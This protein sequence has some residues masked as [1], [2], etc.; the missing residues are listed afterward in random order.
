MR[1]DRDSFRVVDGIADGLTVHDEEG[2]FEYVSPS[3]GALSG[4]EASA[5]IG[6][7][8]CDLGLLH[9]DDVDRAVAAH[10]QALLTSKPW[11]FSYRLRR[12]DEVVVRLE[13]TG[14]V[15]NT[16]AGLRIVATHRETAPLAPLV[17]ELAPE[18]QLRL[19]TQELADRQQRF[20]TMV[21]QRARAPLTSVV[22]IAALLRQRG[23][24]LDP[25]PRR[26]LIE[27]LHTDS[28][29]LMELLKDVA[30]ADKLTRAD[31]AVQ[32]R[33]ADVHALV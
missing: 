8:P 16:A 33:V 15:I 6:G 22:G 19:Q 28:L 14:G 25:N 18:R 20:L 9:P 26:A 4:F 13:S 29:L 17:D 11:R 5:L 31:V 32:R 7:S 2:R 23:D 10:T 1:M 3:F 24:E 21:S 30:E 12:S 27:R